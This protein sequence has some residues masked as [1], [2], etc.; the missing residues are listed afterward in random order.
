MHL[1]AIYASLSEY[2]EL[3]E[4]LEIVE[5]K[6][7]SLHDILDLYSNLSFN[8]S[9]TRLI[10]FEIF[11]LALFPAF[12]ILEHLFKTVIPINFFINLLK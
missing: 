12:H 2:Y 11:L 3:D 7:A 6:I 10:L 9:E 1:K 8:Q 5:G 4:R